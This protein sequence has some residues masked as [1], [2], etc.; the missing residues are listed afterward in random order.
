V[1]V[2]VMVAVAVA[3]GVKVKVAVAVGVKVNVGV[4]VYD[5]GVGVGVGVRVNVG[6][7]VAGGVPWRMIW[8]LSQMALSLF[9]AP[10]ALT[11]RMSFTVSP[12]SALRS[13]SIG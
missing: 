1:L 11:T 13:K 2:G 12:A 6:V 10:F 8:G 3:V 7:G 9:C 5:V 4:G